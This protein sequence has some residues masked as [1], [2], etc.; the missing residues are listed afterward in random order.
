MQRWNCPAR[1]WIFAVALGSAIVLAPGVHSAEDETTRALTTLKAVTKEGKGNEDAGPAWKTLV[2]KGGSAL[3]P[4]LEAIDDANPT[5]ANWLRTAVD[6]IAENETSAGRKLPADKL[7][8]FAKSTKFAATARRL[9]Y[10]LLLSQDPTAKDRLLPEFLNDKSSELRRDAVAHQLAIVE[11][12]A[13]PTIKADLEK[14]FT[15]TRDKDQVELLAK[16]IEENGGKVSISEHFGFI[17]HAALIGPF[18][19]TAGKGFGI[20]YPPESAKDTRG[21]FKGKENAELKWAAFN[22]TDKYGK[23]DLN[24]FL[25]KH[26]DSVAY[27]LAVIVA[28]KETPCEIRVTS[29]TSVQI[30]LNG[31]KLFGRDEYH[32]GAPFD[33][34]LG[35]G[36]LQKGEN[37]IVLKVC[38]NNQ[39]EEWAQ[40]WF[41]QMRVCDDTGGPLT[42]T[43]K[44]M[45]NGKEQSIKLGFI[46]ESPDVKE[47]KK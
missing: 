18:D 45:V 12:L 46:L 41:F 31:K 5:S 22:T 20:A 23:F 34:H 37:V 44:V 8:A 6:A 9:A 3:I 32:H 39:T 43:Q 40:D 33:A 14:L 25:G 4:T 21:K 27:A 11:K 7:E 29:I 30:F 26:K 16:K 42:L 35:K 2:S 13:K 17:T 24:K 38:Q 10:E 47:E 1:R 28:E 36:T 15:F 19:S